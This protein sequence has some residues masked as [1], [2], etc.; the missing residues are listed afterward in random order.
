MRTPELT[1]AKLRTENASRRR[2][3]SFVAT[4]IVTVSGG[5][6]DWIDRSSEDADPTELCSLTVV[7]RDDEPHDVDVVAYD[8][9]ASIVELSG[10][11]D[12]RN[13]SDRSLAAE[14]DL[15]SGV[16]T[17]E[18]QVDENERHELDL[19]DLSGPRSV[20]VTVDEEGRIGFYH[21][22]DCR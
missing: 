12:G 14:D 6:T 4:G 5:C 22:A 13:G 16:T 18:G 10:T 11:V 8:D 1:A 15:P 21:A 9:G 17:I 19:T 7:N 2:V 20:L 3:L